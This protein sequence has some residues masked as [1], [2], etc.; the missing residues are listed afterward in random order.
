MVSLDGITENLIA[1][2]IVLLCSYL[3]GKFGLNLISNKNENI[4]SEFNILNL[5]IFLSILSI[6]NFILNL[7]FWKNQ[8]LTLFLTLISV[9]FI[10]GTIYIYNNQCPNCKKIF[11]AKKI[12]ETKTIKKFTQP[13][14]Y[15][16][17]KVHLYTNGEVYK[18]E[19]IGKEKNRIE[20]WE[21][22]Q[23][24]F[25]CRFCNYMW[26]SGQYDINL[27]LNSR[28]KP[29]IIKTNKRDPNSYN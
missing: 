3:F 12:L 22:K 15:R 11:W 24:F 20:N 6:G 10:A 25:Q 18:K 19:E 16:D 17:K 13:Y 2:A 29:K 28:P 14:K 7:S 4:K 8:N 1:E 9:I 27:D 23:D 5:S 26:D 21:T